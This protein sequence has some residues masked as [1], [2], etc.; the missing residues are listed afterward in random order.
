MITLQRRVPIFQ[1]TSPARSDAKRAF[2]CTLSCYDFSGNNELFLLHFFEQF[3]NA[4]GIG[5]DIL[6]YL[7]LSKMTEQIVT[8]HHPFPRQ[9]RK[10]RRPHKASERLPRAWTLRKFHIISGVS[11]VFREKNNIL[12]TK[13]RQEKFQTKKGSARAQFYLRNVIVSGY[14]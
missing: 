8:M 12:S 14:L 13:L 11:P 3:I 1:A 6:K 7:H 4:A 5:N 10:Y 9:S 2:V